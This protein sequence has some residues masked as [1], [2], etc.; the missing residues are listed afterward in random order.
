MHRS[1][2][3]MSGGVD[4]TLCAYQAA[5]RDQVHGL[6]VDYGQPAAVQEWESCRTFAS[7]LP[8]RVLLHRRHVELA[9]AWAP[10]GPNVIP[11]RN[12][13]LLSV[14]INLALSVG[15]DVVELG[16]IK[17]DRA[18]YVDCG[19]KF[20]KQVLPVGQCFGVLLEFPLMHMTKKQVIHSARRLGIAVDRLWSCY[21]PSADGSPCGECNSCLARNCAEEM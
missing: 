1:V 10:E 21:L 2:V 20:L 7:T 3:L 15:A 17:D 4:S 8:T 11:A 19:Q 12:L 9:G 14:G 16:V 6:F 5:Q 18:D 13:V